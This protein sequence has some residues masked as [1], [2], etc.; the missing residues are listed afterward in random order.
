MSA[1]FLLVAE[2]LKLQLDFVQSRNAAA[3]RTR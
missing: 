1:T 3:D 2:I